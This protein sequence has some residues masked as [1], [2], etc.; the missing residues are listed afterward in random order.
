MVQISYK[1]M[2]R[3]RTFILPEPPEAGFFL[4]GAQPEINLL[5]LKTK[6]FFPRVG[7][8]GNLKNPEPAKNEVVQC[9][10][11]PPPPFASIYTTFTVSVAGSCWCH[12]GILVH[13]KYITGPGKEGDSDRL[14]VG[15]TIIINI[16]EYIRV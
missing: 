12:I 15:P 6:P 7:A 1:A 2:L 3:S 16:K 5:G 11:P 9:T 8:R 10:Y 14:P 13:T 4:A